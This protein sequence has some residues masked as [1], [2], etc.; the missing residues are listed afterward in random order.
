VTTS[1]ADPSLE[2]LLAFLE[3]ARG[4]D[5]TGYKRASLERR[6][7]RRL[8]IVGA[9]TFGDYIDFLEVHPEE[10]EALFDTL[11]INVTE[12]FRDTPV[13][14]YLQQEVIPQLLEAKP[15][16]EPIR[17]WSAGCASGQEA[18][19]AAMLLVEAL[20]PEAF[21]ERVKIYATDIDNEAL[22]T[23][24]HGVYSAREVESVPPELREKYF[25]R[26][27]RK[28]AF[29][30][31]LRRS[32]IFGA[33][34][35]VADAPISRLDLL[36][37]RNTL[38]YFTPE[39]QKRVLGH[40][41]FALREHGILVLGKSEMMVSHR[42]LF[43]AID[44]KKRVFSRNGV[45]SPARARA[46]IRAGAADVPSAAMEEPITRDLALDA[47]P[48][49]QLV[50]S[51]DGLLSFAN[52]A[53]RTRFDLRVDDVG[54]AFHELDVSYRPAELRQPIEQV[55]RERRTVV[56][57]EVRFAPAEG[58]ERF[59]D[60]TVTPLLSAAGE[61][62]GA[63]VLFDDVTR[64]SALQHEVEG[65]RHELEQAYE[66]LQ[67][68]IDELETTNEELQSANEELQTTN[69]ELQSSNEELETMNEELQSTNEELETINDELRDRTGEINELNDFLEAIVTSL[70]VG[71]A[72]LDRGQRVQVW[73]QRAEDLWGVR[74][75]EALQQHFMSLD[76]GLPIDRLTA[77]LRAVL[78][79]ESPRERLSLEA[80]DRRGRAITCV[81]SVLPLLKPHRDGG[82][83]RGA[84]VL[85]DDEAG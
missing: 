76:V 3:Q 34:N 40:F 69:E 35:L 22:D 47:G 26:A 36:L 6:F 52:Q 4:I 21:R 31:A 38:M 72:V 11:L 55:L 51:P 18:Y 60:I 10:F 23:A 73:N 7:R 39:T 70:A 8:E 24:R 28:L 85:M 14:I 16:D 59:L 84:I 53:A 32:V 25:E 66:E 49:A 65:H 9:A 80:V 27:D 64:V 29:S 37:C 2:A 43:T 46:D 20:G 50:V 30:K 71:I 42:E 57:G 68:T 17:V 48:V 62:A 56:L 79:G 1:V 54:R 12:F 82:G 58:E 78:G 63:S 41:H 61:V 81:T 45:K 74:S 77:P 75:D 15:A 5:F 13:W 67:S 83:V 44:L 33:N 19:T